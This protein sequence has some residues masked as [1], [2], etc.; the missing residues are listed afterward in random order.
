LTAN[1]GE[2]DEEQ[3]ALG[4]PDS[5][6][7]KKMSGVGRAGRKRSGNESHCTSEEPVWSHSEFRKELDSAKHVGADKLSNAD[8][9]SFC[10]GAHGYTMAHFWLDA[11]PFFVELWRRVE[12]HRFPGIRTKTE[13]C[14]Q[15][16]CSLRWAEMIIADT[17]KDSNRHKAKGTRK[18][19]E[20][21]SDSELSSCAREHRTD[22]DCADGI[23]RYADRTLQQLMV[24]DWPRFQDA[25]RRLAEFFSKP[26]LQGE[27]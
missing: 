4:L 11:R 26:P 23:A 27:V 24:R 15:I 1:D 20:V 6:E 16:G 5:S 7:E 14:R 25:C 9:L 10:R 12:T 19:S 18:K 21:T 17:A 2:A 3:V 8:L 13:A 22:E